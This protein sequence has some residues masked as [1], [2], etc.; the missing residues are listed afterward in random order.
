MSAAHGQS[1]QRSFLDGCE[2]VIKIIEKNL[3]G[4]QASRQ[5]RAGLF[6]LPEISLLYVGLHA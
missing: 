5:V 3:G 2:P 6:G 1:S 4:C